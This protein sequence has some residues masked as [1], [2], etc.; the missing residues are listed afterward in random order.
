MQAVNGYYSCQTQ[1]I[2]KN[3]ESSILNQ[4]KSIEILITNLYVFIVFLKS[5]Q[6]KVKLI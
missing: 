1:K 2:R 5:H 3:Y 4:F 6:A